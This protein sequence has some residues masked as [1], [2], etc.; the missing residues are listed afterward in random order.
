MDVE[1]CLR[2]ME[3]GGGDIAADIFRAKTAGWHNNPQTRDADKVVF[4]DFH[5]TEEEAEKKLQSLD[6][7]V[8]NIKSVVVSSWEDINL[9]AYAD[10][11][12]SEMKPHPQPCCPNE[13]ISCCRRNCNERGRK[14]VHSAMTIL[15]YLLL[16]LLLHR[17]KANK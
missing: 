9:H 1:G 5:K 13:K 10:D 3:S 14:R 6:S 17:K 7:E 12:M 11:I 4:R 15:S 2:K 16:L 8:S